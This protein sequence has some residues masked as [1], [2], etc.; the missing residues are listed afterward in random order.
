MQHVKTIYTIKQLTNVSMFNILFNKTI[1]FI[2]VNYC[3]NNKIT[4]TTH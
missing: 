1:D 2:N 3:I 4:E